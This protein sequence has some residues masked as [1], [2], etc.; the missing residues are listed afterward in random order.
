ALPPGAQL[1]PLGDA[2]D[3]PGDLLRGQPLELLPRP[4]L[5]LVNLPDDGEV[6]HLQ[7]RAWR[8]AGGEDREAV[9]QVLAGR[10]LR[11]R[12]PAAAPE[13]PRDKPFPHLPSL[14]ARCR[15]IGPLS[16]PVDR[17]VLLPSDRP[18]RHPT[19]ATSGLSSTS[20]E[21]PP[22][23]IKSDPSSSGRRLPMPP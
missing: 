7:G 9:L 22:V 11:I 3:V 16:K 1:R 17:S 19:G 18:R 10:Q 21:Q 12:P 15:A 13:A 2:V 23:L 6:P 14:L 4:P 5:G 8:G 20:V